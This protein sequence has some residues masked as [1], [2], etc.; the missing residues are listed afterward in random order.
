VQG[1]RIP[2]AGAGTVWATPAAC[3]IMEPTKRGQH[4]ARAGG[5]GRCS[6]RARDLHAAL[7]L[8]IYL[9][10][11]WRCPRAV[12][13]E[14]YRVHTGARHLD[15][16]PG[17]GY[18]LAVAELPGGTG[19]TLLDP[20][21]EVLAHAAK[22]LARHAPAT[23]RADACEPLPLTDPFDSAALN[24]VLHCIDGAE[25]KAAAVRHVAAALDD[26]GVLFGASVLGT[27]EAH[28]RL[29]RT[30][31]TALNRRDIFSNLADTEVGLR[32]LLNEAFDDVAL[33]RVG[34]VAVFTARH[35]RRPALGS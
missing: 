21:P 30:A 20:N 16:G 32:D 35:P 23:V 19:I 13:A 10:W 9:R 6:C 12:L 31:L 4:G 33:E 7:I 29:G 14:R 25:R 5:A 18:F 28:G 34:A 8:R 22:R 1:A 15:V 17:T 2:P 24:L 27:P 3:C 11:V 26:G